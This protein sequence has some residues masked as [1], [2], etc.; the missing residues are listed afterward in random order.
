M[1]ELLVLVGRGNLNLKET[2]SG[3][4]PGRVQQMQHR[5]GTRSA[6]SIGWTDIKLSATTWGGSS[7]V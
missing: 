5:S 2:P 6:A 4:P 3:W 7:F 1:R